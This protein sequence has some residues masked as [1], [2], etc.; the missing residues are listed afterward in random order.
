MRACTKRPV[1]LRQIEYV[2]D[3]IEN[4]IRSDYKSQI[5]STQLG[6][7]VLD[8]LAKVD[9]VAYI[10]FAS[11]YKDFQSAEEFSHALDKIHRS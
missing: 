2:V 5:K 9:D 1:T 6:E 10:R 7:M 11:V 8:E 4:I 3:T